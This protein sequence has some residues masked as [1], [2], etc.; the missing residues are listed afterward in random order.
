METHRIIEFYIGPRNC[1]KSV[2]VENKILIFNKLIYIATLPLKAEYKNS[3]EKHRER[4]GNN[5]HT[6]EICFDYYQ[7]ISMISSFLQTVDNKSAC[8]LDG[9]WTWYHF[10]NELRNKINPIEFAEGIVHF[11]HKSKSNWYLVDIDYYDYFQDLY[12]IHNK[13]ISDLNIV[14]IIKKQDYTNE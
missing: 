10:Q 13:I 4:R 14:E 11:I 7:D 3:I 6:I 2:Y 8:M 12:T 5:W 1:G 9:I